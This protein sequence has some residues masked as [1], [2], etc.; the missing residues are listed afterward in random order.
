M[1]AGARVEVAPYK[2][3][4]ADF[5][6]WKPSTAEQPGWDSP[7]GRGRP[8]WHIECSAMAEAHLGET[9]DIH[10]GGLDLIFPHHENEIA[11]SRCA[12]GGDAVRATSGCTT[13]I[14]D[15]RAARRCRSRSATSSPCASCWRKVSAARRSAWRC[16]PATTARRSTS[17]ARRSPSARASSTA[18][19]A[20][21][22]ASTPTADRPEPPATAAGRP[23]RRPQHA[24][25]P[26]RAA[27]AGHRNEQGEGRRQTRG[28]G[29]RTAGA[30]ARCSAC[31]RTTR[32]PGSR[33]QAAEGALSAEEIEAHDR[34]PHRRPQS[35]GLRRSRPPPRRP[36]GPGHHPRRRPRRHDLAPR[37]LN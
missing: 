6:L 15:G 14:V 12:H 24:A 10:G 5:V 16:S 22:A 26:R 33:A 28:P 13:A 3:D 1:I 9:F 30:A 18:S 20:R 2:R 37:G 36:A 32:T 19:T 27:R 8:G 31:C 7:W 29:R 23:G 21:C 35:Q 4:P 25:G 34:R 11:Q 17:P